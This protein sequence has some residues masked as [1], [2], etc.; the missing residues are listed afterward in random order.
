MAEALGW[1]MTARPSVTLSATSGAGGPRPLDGGSGA[2]ETLRRERRE[3]RWLDTGTDW[4]ADGSSQLRPVDDP[5]PTVSGK[6]GG[7]W[8]W[9]LRNGNQAKATVRS[10]DEPAPT[11]AFGHAAGSV[12]WVHERPATTLMGDQ[13]VF[14]PGGHHE[15]GKQSQNAIRI[16]LAEAL[17]LQGFPADFPVQG[18]KTQTFQQVGNAIPP[19]LAAAVLR[20]LLSD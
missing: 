3:G 4:R 15:P 11:V 6:S 8:R 10:A 7:Q 5:A 13:R 12:E 18:N 19:P 2:R 16:T 9:G 17:V 20:A 14:Q 1:G